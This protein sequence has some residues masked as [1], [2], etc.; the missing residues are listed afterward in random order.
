[1]NSKKT[2]SIIYYAIVTIIFFLFIREYLSDNSIDFVPK[3]DYSD[4]RDKYY[5]DYMALD[6]GDYRVTI[7]YNAFDDTEIAMYLNNT[8]PGAV[9]TLDRD[10]NEFTY[11]LHMDEYNDLIHFGYSVEKPEEFT[12]K[13]IHIKSDKPI[14]TDYL[15]LGLIFLVVATIAYLFIMYS[16]FLQNPR[17]EKLL[18]AVIF[19]SVLF[20]SVPLFSETLFWGADAP[21]HVMRLEGVK[22]ALL[23]RQIPVFLF[24]KNANG[25]GLL[26]YLYPNL[27]LYIPAICRIMGMS[28]PFTM[29]ELY[30]FTNVLTAILAYIGSGS[31]FNKR[32]ARYLFSIIYVLLPYRLVNIYTRADFGEAMVMCFIPL[33]I[34]GLYVCVSDKSTWDDKAGILSFIIGMTGVIHSHVLSSAMMC[35]LAF[36]YALIFVKNVLRKDKLKVVLYSIGGTLLLNIGYIVPFIKMYSFGLN[37]D[38]ELDRGVIFEGKYKLAELFKIHDFS[39][40]TAWGGVSVIGVLGIL[41][42]IAG[43]LISIRNKDIDWFMLISGVLAI[44]LL[45]SNGSE[46]PWYLLKGINVVSAVMRVFEFSFR[47]MLIASPLIAVVTVY[48][49]YRLNLSDKARLILT[50]IVIITA[51]IC[52][53]PGIIGEI[54]SEPYIGRLGGG[55]SDNIL[56]EYLPEGVTP[57]VYS[58]DRLFWSSENLTFENYIKN[59]LRIDFD[60][61]IQGDTEEWLAPPI[62]Y[63]P[64]YRAIAVTASGEEYDLGVS[65]GAYYRTSI[66]LPAALSGSH[67]KLFFKGIWYFYF[68]YVISIISMII[69]LLIVIKNLKNKSDTEHNSDLDSK[70]YVREEGTL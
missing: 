49:L 8:D 42:F 1:M 13:G 65:Q 15:I 53:T 9:A 16:H 28:I 63:Y 69:L 6:R 2:I 59:G 25:Y 27:F 56:R 32:E 60:Y 41:V 58:E 40:N 37:F 31:F 44:V 39:N 55:A 51:F 26:G 30:V 61:Q 68:A 3:M 11:E 66:A 23:N 7:Y 14:F 52:A 64:G 18:F 34:G 5:S 29:N 57:E 20:S 67:V 22:D 38:V 54:K 35:G 19:V 33:I 36:L 4:S 45:I 21:A 17:M 48:Y 12:I 62:L 43:T 47:V 24:P 50:G 70:H 10:E 46:F